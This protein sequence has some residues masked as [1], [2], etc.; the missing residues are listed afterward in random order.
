MYQDAY[1]F[2]QHRC[3]DK[4]PKYRKVFMDFNLEL[5]IYPATDCSLSLS[6]SLSLVY[7]EE[8]MDERDEWQD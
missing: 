2:G 1:T 5:N 4:L 8:I 7:L 3:I 6:L